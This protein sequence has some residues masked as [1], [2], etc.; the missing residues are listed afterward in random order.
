MDTPEWWEVYHKQHR[1][2]REWV[3]DGPEVLDST[4]DI[5]RFLAKREHSRV[6]HIGCGSST[7]H[8]DLLKVGFSTVV[9]VD[10][11]EAVIQRMVDQHAAEN[12]QFRVADVRDLANAD[13]GPLFDCVV[14]KGLFDCLL[15]NG[16]EEH[17]ENNVL[18]VLKSLKAVMK[19]HAMVVETSMFEEK[20]RRPY[21]ELGG[22]FEVKVVVVELNPLELPH[23]KCSFIYILVPKLGSETESGKTGRTDQDEEE[24]QD[25]D[26]EIP[27]INQDKSA[28][29]AT[30]D[31]SGV[32]IPSAEVD[33]S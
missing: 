11:D 17:K 14:G 13:L 12:V 10:F 16:T 25:N 20:K 8:K 3:L 33:A 26:D 30:A 2:F 5:L 23:Q 9:N 22:L 15:S 6:L 19:P 29:T 7:L 18:R 4:Q 21:M 1:D 27:V 24:E 31:T 32:A 28:T